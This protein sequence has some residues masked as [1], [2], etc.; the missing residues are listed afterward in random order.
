MPGSERSERTEGRPRSERP[1]LPGVE[2]EWRDEARS[3]DSGE[4]ALMPPG[5]ERGRMEPRALRAAECA[6]EYGVTG[7]SDEAG[8][9]LPDRESES[10]DEGSP[11]IFIA[12]EKP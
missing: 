3:S 8:G 10:G 1:T 2:R 6:D 12:R 11:C 4:D 5:V 7:T 9:E